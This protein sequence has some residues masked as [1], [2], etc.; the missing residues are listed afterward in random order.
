M[1]RI[2][3]MFT[4]KLDRNYPVLDTG[5]PLTVANETGSVRKFADDY[6]PVFFTDMRMGDERPEKVYFESL[7]P[8]TRLIFNYYLAWENETHPQ[9]IAHK[10]YEGF[11]TAVYGSIRDIEYVQIM[12]SFRTGAVVGFAFERDPSG[13]FDHPAPKHDVIVCER[14]SDEDRFRISVNGAQQGAMPVA[15][16]GKRLCI[17]VASWNHIYDFYDGQ[18]ARA[19]DPPL[20]PLTDKLYKMYYMARRSR[21]PDRS[22]Q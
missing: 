17:L 18:G 21:P 16:E 1:A 5:V 10:L 4:L 7:A 20:V 6:R 22:S 14:K 15:F 13:R 19:D 2:N 9:P 3:E 11:R 8:G 12:V